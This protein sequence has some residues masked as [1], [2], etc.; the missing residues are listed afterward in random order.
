MA[1]HGAKNNFILNITSV[2][3]RAHISSPIRFMDHLRW[4]RMGSI[5]NVASRRQGRAVIG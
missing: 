5:K 1:V 3:N 2:G 4:K